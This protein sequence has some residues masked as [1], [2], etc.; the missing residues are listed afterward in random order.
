M[1]LDLQTTIATDLLLNLKEDPEVFTSKLTR[2]VLSVLN[3]EIKKAAESVEGTAL[4]AFYIF[5]YS[6][7]QCEPRIKEALKEWGHEDIVARIEWSGQGGEV[8]LTL[9]LK[10]GTLLP[11]QVSRHFH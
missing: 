1:I 2:E 10:E 11:F 3:Q 4:G 6:V 8:L 7:R 5:N 9:S